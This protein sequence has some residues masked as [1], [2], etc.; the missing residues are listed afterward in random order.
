MK[1][2]TNIKRYVIFNK[3]TEAVTNRKFSTREAARNYK[4]SCAKP[5]NWGIMD[6][7]SGSYIR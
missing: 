3:K 2:N 5:R 1:T 4:R 7:V 6:V